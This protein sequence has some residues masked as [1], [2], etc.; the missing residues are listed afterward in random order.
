MTLIIQRPTGSNLT[1]R[2]QPSAWAEGGD[3]VYTI[4]VGGTTYRVHE[5]K[6]VGSSSLNVL[7]GGTFEYLA[8]G[9]GGGGGSNA[10]GGGG[11]GYVR[12][13]SASIVTGVI[14]ISVGAG[15]TGGPNNSPSGTNGQVSTMSGLITVTAEGGGGG[16]SIF[17][18]PGSAGT[19]GGG[20]TCLF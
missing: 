3:L 13:G 10:G 1:L 16:A 5:F 14:A 19:G 17:S 6:T 12:S 9:G 8:V 2:N 7:E 4:V 15:G 20:G 18:A 11:G